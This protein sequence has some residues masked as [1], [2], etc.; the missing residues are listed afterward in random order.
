[1][2][3][4]FEHSHDR[5]VSGTSAADAQGITDADRQIAA[6]RDLVELGEEEARVLERE[7]HGFVPPATAKFVDSL[8]GTLLRIGETRAY[9]AAPGIAARARR[10][11]RRY[12]QRLFSCE[13]GA[14]YAWDQQAVAHSHSQIGIEPGWLL[15][16]YARYVDY[17]AEEADKA[18]KDD[19]A[20]ALKVVQAGVKL[21]F[22]DAHEAIAEL[23]RVLLER[24]KALLEAQEQ[25][26]GRNRELVRVNDDR[27]RF[28]STV[29]HELKTPLTSLLA[30]ADVL[31]KNRSETLSPRDIQHLHAIQ[32]DGRR[33][34]MLIGDL[35]DVSNARSGTFKLF[36]SRFDARAML[37]EFRQ[38]FTPVLAEKQQWIELSCE[39]GHMAVV[40]DRDR[41]IQVMSNLVGN[42]SKFSPS[43]TRVRVSASLFNGKLSVSVS[44]QGPGILQGEAQ[45][46]FQPFHRV[47]N[48]LGRKVPGT[49][50]GL[51]VCRIIIGL[52][53][54]TIGLKSAP[55]GGTEVAW[56]IPDAPAQPLEDVAGLAPS[57]AG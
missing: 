14:D 33:L 22:H 46:L 26:N 29:T 28:L 31:S 56:W 9:F 12:F 6:F 53:G 23:M 54:G 37:D 34:E 35:I 55:G 27:D 43:G 8:H 13:Y 25:I 3:S 11:Q 44:D 19:P 7:A 16:V 42:A 45:Q 32:R 36:H 40:A 15:G 2:V 38:G 21:A 10:G 49:G 39:G 41:L 30:F 17:L 5:S 1:M 24:H 20:G 50:L 52:H 48:E 51:Y 18:F 47:D 57:A 4:A